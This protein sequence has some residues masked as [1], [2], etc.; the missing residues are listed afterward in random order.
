MK[1]FCRNCSEHYEEYKCEICAKD[2]IHQCRECHDETAH[3]LI[4]NQNINTFE[5]NKYLAYRQRMGKRKT[6]S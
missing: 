5:G 4:S 1:K 2:I 3:S 6:D